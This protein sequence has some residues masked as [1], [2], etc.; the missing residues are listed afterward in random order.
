MQQ[1]AKPAAPT[2]DDVQSVAREVIGIE[3]A[4]QY[5]DDDTE[6]HQKRHKTVGFV[7]IHKDPTPV[8]SK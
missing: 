1:I 7:L 3:S 4:D 2:V 6:C 8:L 5:T